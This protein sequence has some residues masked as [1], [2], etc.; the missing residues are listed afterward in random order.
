META[1]SK[2]LKIF[3]CYAREDQALREKLGYHLEPLRRA[4][5]I[6]SWHDRQIQPGME[7][8]QEIQ[9]NLD[10]SDIVLLLV[11]PAFM[12]SDYCYSVEMARALQRHES[13][14]ARVIPVILRPVEWKTTIIGQLQALP[15][16]GKPIT[17]WRN[18]DKAYQ[19]VTRGLQDVVKA[20]HNRHEAKDF[21]ERGRVLLE[22]GKY[23]AA[24]L[25]F[26]QAIRLD[27]YYF[28]QKAIT[29][30]Q[31]GRNEQALDACNQALQ[32]R[33]HRW[34]YREKTKILTKL[35]RQEEAKQ[36]A[37][38]THRLYK[39]RDDFFDEL[40]GPG[41]VRQIDEKESS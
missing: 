27:Y 23:E 40:Y 28:L 25:A 34:A 22:N 37:E 19:D 20:L 11:S 21:E 18:R 26:D 24:L 16:D 39:E 12:S 17:L 10:S 31:L 14:V 7:W 35:G 2:I 6:V 15:S 41:T 3:Y 33:K 29:L 38:E 30:S 4:E 1:E 9:I 5:L 13:R 32:L 8:E 36:A